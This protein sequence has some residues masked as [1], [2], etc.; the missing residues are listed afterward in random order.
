MADETSTRGFT[1]IELMIVV[2]VIGVLVGFAIVPTG[3]VKSKAFVT[4]M[5]ADLKSISIAQELFYDDART[6]TAN[7]SDLSYTGSAGVQITL[8]SNGNGW[9]AQATHP[10]ARNR[11]CA[12]Y[13]GPITPLAPASKHGLIECK[14]TIK[15]PGC[16]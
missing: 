1:L 12:I 16:N 4:T 14:T 11:E 7:M 3:S 15:A 5:R 2:T 6:Y 8:Q 10:Q 13:V 9:T